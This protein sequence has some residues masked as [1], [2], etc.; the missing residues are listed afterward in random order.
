MYEGAPIANDVVA[1]LLGE[2]LGAAKLV[3]GVAETDGGVLGCLSLL[4]HG[5]SSFGL[6]V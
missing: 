3:L 4:I 1:G 6:V 5:R 2:V